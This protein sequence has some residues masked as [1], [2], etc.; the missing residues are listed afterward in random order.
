[1]R[2]TFALVCLIGCLSMFSTVTAAVLYDET[3][4]APGNDMDA[5]PA[6]TGHTCVK[7]TVTLTAG[8]N[9]DIMTAILTS[10][11]AQTMGSTTYDSGDAFA[12]DANSKAVTGSI[13]SFE[14]FASSA[15]CTKTVQLTST[16]TY[17]GGVANKG[18]DTSARFLIESIESCPTS[19]ANTAAPAMV[20]ISAL[21]GA[22][23]IFA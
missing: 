8:K 10:A 12:A 17:V 18:A 1:M 13:C 9:S 20:I 7:Y 21:V 19:G 23:A 6:A 4:V 5:T 22:L 11:N 2:R 16:E 3:G 15:T 14:D